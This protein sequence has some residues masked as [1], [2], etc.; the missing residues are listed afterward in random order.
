MSTRLYLKPGVTLEQEPTARCPYKGEKAYLFLQN[1][2]FNNLSE[3]DDLSLS[4]VSYITIEE[5]FW[6]D[7]SGYSFTPGCYEGEGFK[8]TI[9]PSSAG[10]R[11]ISQKSIRSDWKQDVF[12][13]FDSV[14]IAKSFWQTLT[15]GELLPTRPL[16]T[17]PDLTMANYAKQA[18]LAVGLSTRISELES[19]I[20]TLMNQLKAQGQL[21]QDHVLTPAK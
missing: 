3:I 18:S 14:S 1:H 2:R 12:G 15:G 20:A 17:E 9:S 10:E 19:T 4:N 21:I 16:C 5:S 7:L 11:S 13:R 8:V 6:K